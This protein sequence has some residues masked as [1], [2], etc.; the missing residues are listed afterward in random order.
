MQSVRR[1]QS[2]QSSIDDGRRCSI[3]TQQPCRCPQASPGQLSVKFQVSA[4]SHDWFQCHRLVYKW[5]ENQADTTWQIVSVDD[6]WA[7]SRRRCFLMWVAY[8]ILLYFLWIIPVPI[9]DV[10]IPAVMCPRGLGLVLEAPRGQKAV[11][12]ALALALVASPWPWSWPWDKVLGRNVNSNK[13]YLLLTVRAQ[14][15]KDVEH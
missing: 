5:A 13:F 9:C 3:C 12:V 11:A 8:S 2:G 1:V 4:W 14:N 10:A 6:S 15:W 7:T